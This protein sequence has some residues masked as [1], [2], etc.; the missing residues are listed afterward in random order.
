MRPA[1]YST[2]SPDQFA[3][4]PRHAEQAQAKVSVAGGIR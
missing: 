2:R 3:P 1:A 4:P